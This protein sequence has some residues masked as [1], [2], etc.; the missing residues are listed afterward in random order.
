MKNP[1]LHAR[2]PAMACLWALVC[3]L[4]LVLSGCGGGGNSANTS[5]SGGSSGGT[6]N[7]SVGTATLSGV[8][9]VG[10]PLV[11]A[12]ITVLDAL[13]VAQGSTTTAITDGS[14][15]LT[16]STS[17][18]TLPLFVQAVGTDLQGLPVVVHTVVQSLTTGGS[19]SNIVHIN[20]LTNAI[21]AILLG[22]DPRPYFQDPSTYAS[23]SLLG[24]R[25][26]LA[27][28]N[29]F[30]QG[31]IRNNLNDA[32]LTTASSVDFFSDPTFHAD[33]TRVDA[34]LEGLRISFGRAINDHPLMHL[35]NRIAIGGAP[36]V[37][38]DLT[39]AKAGLTAATPAVA[40]TSILSS[41][42]TTTGTSSIMPSVA[43]L[44][45]LTSTINMGLA[46]RLGP[47]D[48][49][50]LPVFS[51][52][53][54]HFDGLT[55]L[56]TA[57]KL[58]DYGLAGYQLSNF[59]ITGCLDDPLPNSGCAHVAVSAFVRNAAGTVVDIFHDVVGYTNT[60]GWRL[61]GND[62][63]TPWYI[64][65]ITWLEM[66]ATGARLT[67]VSPNPGQGMQVLI[68]AREF[69]QATIQTPNNQSM[70]FYHC[71][72]TP[73]TYLCLNTTETGD[74]VADYVLRSSILDW[75]GSIDARLG[76]RYRIQTVTLGNG[77]EDN[78]SRVTVD[79]PGTT[80]ITTTT[81]LTAYPVP[82]NLT[83]SPLTIAAFTAGLTVDW[84]TWAAA[85]PNMRVVEI[86][87]VIR[88]TVTAAIK[89]TVQV[90]P[91]TGTQATLPAFATIPVDAETYVLWMT[92]EDAEGRR[93]L[94]KITAQ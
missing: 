35:S 50:M 34:V 88:S 44:N 55:G 87:G 53:Y 93:Y 7:L 47:L 5:S 61:A 19:T 78:T 66:D 29:T 12:R 90:L 46:Q 30:I 67:S 69:M 48:L 75:V 24:N 84:S 18:R 11:G 8:A 33:K 80:G 52:S 91:L 70:P 6:A 74:L 86:S 14:Y 3:A 83:A 63:Q 85:H 54:A 13:G 2:W 16:L 81:D 59:Q 31:V 9:A 92:A 20:P 58:S 32:Q 4:G 76:A 38:V 89:Q 22:G 42:T 37:S 28:A 1:L 41:L 77:T 57:M 72:A 51:Y 94:S 73:W 15:Q 39:L 25:L 43:T 71:N 10:S 49:A 36:E 65:P 68:S 26:A 45:T 21:V 64:H 27:A 79:L 23:W 60:T 17:S 40:L 56:D 62:R 82:N